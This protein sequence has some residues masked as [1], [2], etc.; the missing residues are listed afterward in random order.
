MIQHFQDT[1][2]INCYCGGADL[3]ITTTANPQSHEVKEALLPGQ[4]SADR[5]DLVACVFK[6]RMD[7]IMTDLTKKNAMG[8]IRAWVHTT[9]FQKRG[10]PHDHMLVCVSSEFKLRT[11]EDVDS[12][13]SAEI[14]DQEKD[15]EL[16]DFVMKSMIHGPC[17]EQN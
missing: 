1:L 9:E 14:P 3:F 13:I 8:R 2:A 7:S 5:P 10:N 6:R 11:P 15:P 4:Q 17:G 12:L 16:H